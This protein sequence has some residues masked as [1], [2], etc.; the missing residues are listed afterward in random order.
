MVDLSKEEQTYYDPFDIFSST[1]TEDKIIADDF[2]TLVFTFL[3]VEAQTK[4]LDLTI[5]DVKFV[6]VA[7]DNR[8]IVEKEQ[9]FE[10]EFIAY[11]NPLKG[12]VN[13]LLFS[14]IDAEA[15]VI[16]TDITRKIIHKSKAQL[17]A[18]KNELEF[19]FKVKTGV[20][21]L[22]ISSSEGNYG[23]SKIIFRWV[24]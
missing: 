23:T 24:N 19:D 11:P 21:L 6:K 8:I 3:S 14:K 15:K 13:V 16:L 20:Y 12:N 22:K 2:T 1:G 7:G 4:E 18:G 9:T 5:S 17:T 10:N